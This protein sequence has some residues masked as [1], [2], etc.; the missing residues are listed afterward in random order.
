M[1][2]QYSIMLYSAFLSVRRLHKQNYSHF[3]M[4]LIHELLK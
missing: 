4:E 3:E 1:P 2:A